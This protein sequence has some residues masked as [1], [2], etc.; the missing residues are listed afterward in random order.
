MAL[1]PVCVNMALLS[2]SG[3]NEEALLKQAL[4]MSMQVDTPSGVE[5]EVKPVV[6]P[7]F[8][9]MTEEEQIAY[10]MQMSLAADA[11]NVLE[12]SLNWPLYIV[13]I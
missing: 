1:L 8:S 4:E 12:P 3:N 6:A 10:A 11:G 2:V 13:H 9:S 7:D 5:P